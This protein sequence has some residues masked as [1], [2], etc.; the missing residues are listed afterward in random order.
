MRAI[1]HAFGDGDVFVEWLVARVDHDRAVKAR[2]DAI[3]TGLFVAVI[4]MH[5]ENG[6]G[7]NLFGGADDRFEHA[8]VGVFARAFGEL[9]DE[10]RLA[11]DAAAEQAQ[12]SVPGC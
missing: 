9:D 3:V 6:F 10:G 1:D 8:L 12:S 7:K 2:I 11:L 5:G 4:E